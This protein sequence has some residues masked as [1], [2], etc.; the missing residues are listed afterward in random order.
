MADS[1][2]PHN[3]LVVDQFTRMAVPFA[4]M[5][6]HSDEQAMRLLAGSAAVT[7]RDRVLD[8]CCGT[9]IVAFASAPAAGHVAGIDLTPAMI[10]QARRLQGRRGLTNLSW[11]VGDVARLPF[12]DATFSVVV[13]RYAFHH[14]LDPAAVLG[15]MVRVCEPGGGWSSPTSSRPPSSKARRTTTWRGCATRRTCGRC[16]WT[17]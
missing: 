7:T 15:E 6:A 11:H 9:G 1:E 3:R 12:A 4:E 14:L 16:R 5:P 10:E 8:V 13:S 2:A 17:N